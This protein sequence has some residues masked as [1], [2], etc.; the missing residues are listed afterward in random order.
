[1]AALLQHYHAFNWEV[2]LG[3]RAF[4]YTIAALRR[5]HHNLK[6]LFY[7]DSLLPEELPGEQAK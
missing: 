7:G 5:R 6:A 3:G 4:D 2:H 1:M